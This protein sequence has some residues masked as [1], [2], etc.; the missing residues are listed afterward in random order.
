MKN[1]SEQNQK[2]YYYFC[3]S[4][5]KAIGRPFKKLKHR[6]FCEQTGKETTI[7]LIT[8]TRI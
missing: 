5:K 4:C 8:K 6:S 1:K 3:R 2:M 7:T